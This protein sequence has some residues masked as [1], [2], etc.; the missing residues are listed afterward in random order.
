M[1]LTYFEANILAGFFLM[2]IIA[3]RHGCYSDFTAGIL[4][5]SEKM[6]SYDKY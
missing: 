5:L 1:L 6:I 3:A 4:A 2:L